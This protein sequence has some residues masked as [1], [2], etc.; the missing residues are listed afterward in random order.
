M[1][2][3]IIKG[4]GVFRPGIDVDVNGASLGRVVGN[5]EIV[6]DLL[7][8]RGEVLPALT[9][10]ERWGVLP[11]EERDRAEREW[12]QFVS[13]DAWIQ[14]MSGIKTRCIADEGV[15]PADLAT[16]AFRNACRDA[17][18]PVESVDG[19]LFGSVLGDFNTTPPSIAVLTEKV[20]NAAHVQDNTLRGD[21]TG[22]DISS[23][24]T[25]FLKVLETGYAFVKAGLRKRMVVIGSDVMHNTVSAYNR[26]PRMLLGDGAGALALEASE[27]DSFLGAGTTYSCFDGSQSGL[28]INQ[29]GGNAFPIDDPAIIAD[30][31]HH[32]HR[33]HMDGAAVLAYITRHL[34]T[35]IM[36]AAAKAGVTLDQ[37]KLLAIHQAN[38]RIIE[39][40]R[41][42]LVKKG[43]HSDAVFIN[44]DRYGNATSASVPLVLHGAREAGRLHTGDLVCAVAMGG[45]LSFHVMF[46]HW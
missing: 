22:M 7:R 4:I 19:I 8:R 24:C 43:L 34:P 16:M 42:R 17:R 23:A 25:T 46:F 2:G 10:P 3:A 33:M 38:L 44:I 18:W 31:I 15:T 12:K 11:P 36:A 21:L 32:L 45:G 20:R 40:V 5:Q 28:I 37:V 39:L 14:E 6:D 29:Y 13:S 26:S 27:H 9:P 30:K 1:P 41:D 35:I